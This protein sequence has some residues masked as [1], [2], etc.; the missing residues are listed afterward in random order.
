MGWCPCTQISFIPTHWKISSSKSK[1]DKRLK[2]W[3]TL[4]HPNGTGHSMVMSYSN[5]SFNSDV[6]FK[7]L[8]HEVGLYFLNLHIFAGI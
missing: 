5:V 4:P 8:Q 6:F 2:A 7:A 3:I 1:C